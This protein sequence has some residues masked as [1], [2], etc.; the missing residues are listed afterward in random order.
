MALD[1]K[2][3]R[4]L[5]ILSRPDVLDRMDLEGMWT[6]D[7]ANFTAQQKDLWDVLDAMVDEL[8]NESESISQTTIAT[9][10]TNVKNAMD[11]I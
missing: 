8:E 4:I 3:K 11:A 10:T 7:P 9:V 2:K 1:R 5:I 6:T